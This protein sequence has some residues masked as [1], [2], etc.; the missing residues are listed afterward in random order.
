[1]QE[2][3]DTPAGLPGGTARPSGRAEMLGWVAAMVVLVLL[4]LVVIF[5]WV[6]A[7][8]PIGPDPAVTCD[9]ALFGRRG[10]CPDALYQPQRTLAI[11][12]LTAAV[13]I[14]AALTSSLVG[15]RYRLLRR[16]PG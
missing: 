6:W 11:S 7:E 14:A 1:M 16:P 4:S 3:D 13:L 9:R 10:G 15:R 8:H 5:G 12:C 2:I